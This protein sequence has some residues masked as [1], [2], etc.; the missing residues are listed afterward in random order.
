MGAGAGAA[1]GGP[2]APVT[3]LIGGGGAAL[4]T[5]FGIS[6]LQQKVKEYFGFDDTLQR[7]ANAQAN[8]ASSFIGEVAPMALPF[9]WGAAGANL[10]QRLASRGLSGVIGGG[11]EAAQQAIGDEPWSPG[12]IAAQTGAGA[13]FAKP[14]AVITSIE[15]RA[16]AAAGRTPVRPTPI[17]EPTPTNWPEGTWPENAPGPTPHWPEGTW[18]E[19]EPAPARPP[20]P[21]RPAAEPQTG[22]TRDWPES[23]WPNEEPVQS[24][25]AE[26]APEAPSKLPAD[27][28]VEP[29]G[30]PGSEAPAGVA[31]AQPPPR[32]SAEPEMTRAKGREDYGKKNR[33]RPRVL[34]VASMS[35]L[36]RP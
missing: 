2:A 27:T 19:G 34:R 31:E 16:A 12:R 15:E 7:T 29:H 5:A 14:R 33:V 10:T 24:G 23:T 8:P 17:A 26:A 1:L 4:A 21:E 36:I 30:S 3:A 35:D 28:P 6:A 22:P 32:E 9:G 13:L 25:K 11:V 20:P 18:P